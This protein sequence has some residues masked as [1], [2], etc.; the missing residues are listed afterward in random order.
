MQVTAVEP[1]ATGGAYSTRV[2]LLPD[3]G[4]WPVNRSGLKACTAPGVR[5]GRVTPHAG[6]ADA[7]AEI[8][9][10]QSE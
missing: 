10:L 8:P 3:L 7:Y 1:G 2:G 6:G 5:A 4:V 9:E